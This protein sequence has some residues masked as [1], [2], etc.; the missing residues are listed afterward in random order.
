LKI[1]YLTVIQ[2]G[3]NKDAAA[4]ISHPRDSDVRERGAQLAC[5]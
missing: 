4:D 2:Q 1:F 3:D 5:Y